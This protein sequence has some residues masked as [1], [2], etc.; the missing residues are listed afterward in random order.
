V[1]DF[2]K[3]SR[4]TL[5]CLG[6]QSSFAGTVGDLKQISSP[7]PNHPQSTVE[8]NQLTLRIQMLERMLWTSIT[9][10]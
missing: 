8:I 4:H 2:T 3:K 10:W 1:S 7:M 9:S 5:R 6:R